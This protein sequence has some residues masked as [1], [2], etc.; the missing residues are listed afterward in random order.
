MLAGRLS[1]VPHPFSNPKKYNDY[2]TF[3]YGQHPDIHL[4]AVKHLGGLHFESEGITIQPF[5]DLQHCRY[6][7]YWKK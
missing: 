6:V 1:D 7:V 5:Y 4:G 2:Y 3:D